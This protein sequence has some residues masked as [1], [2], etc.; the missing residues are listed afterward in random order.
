METWVSSHK[1]K[2]APQPH[3]K[4]DRTE[5][6]SSL[7]LAYL[8]RTDQ[9]TS[10]FSVSGIAHENPRRRSFEAGARLIGGGSHCPAHPREQK[11]EAL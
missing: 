8:E 4:A 1:S 10:A 2:E 7:R 9:K 11:A 5:G 3:G 6:A